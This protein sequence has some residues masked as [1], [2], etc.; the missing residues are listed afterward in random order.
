MVDVTSGGP[1]PD[2]LD[3]E[4]VD[5]MELLR[6]EQEKMGMAMP[7]VVDAPVMAPVTFAAE[8]AADMPALAPLELTS[9][10][11]DIDDVAGAAAGIAAAA[12][13]TAAAMTGTTSQTAGGVSNEPSMGGIDDDALVTSL[14]GRYFINVGEPLPEYA[15]ANAMAFEAM[16]RNDRSRPLM[17]L[18]LEP[19]AQPRYDALEGLRGFAMN[20]MLKL[21]DW[22]V[23]DWPAGGSRFAIVLERP[24]GYRVINDLTI[25]QSGMGDEE[26]VEGL[27]RPLLNTLKD[28]AARGVTHRAIRPTN[29]FYTDMTRRTMVLGECLTGVPALDQPALFETIESAQAH[30]AGRG[31]GT[32]QN[33][34]YS[35]GATIVYLLLGRNPVPD[36]SDD[37]L[38]RE[39]IEVG[40]YMALAGQVRVPVSLIEPLRG[41]LM[42]DERD[43]WTVADLDLWLSGRRQSPRQSK[44]P[45]RASR[46]FLVGE[47]ECFNVRTLGHAFAVNWQE[48]V[49][50]VRS[51]QLDSWLRRSMMEEPKAEAL[52]NAVYSTASHVTG[53]GAEERLVA[54]GCITLDPKGPIRY[55]GIGVT[56]DGIGPAMTVAL[57]DADLRQALTEIIS[58]RLPIHWVA[59]QG[60]PNS[61]DVRIAQAMEKLPGIIEQQAVGLGFERCLYETNPMMRCL[62]PMFEREFVVDISEVMPALDRLGQT[63]DRPDMPYDRHLIGF[64]AARSRRWSEDLLRPLASPDTII[65]AIG[66]LRLF[67]YIQENNEVGPVPGFATWM[68]QMLAPVL[69]NY[70]HRA[71]RQRVQAKVQA[72]AESGILSELLAVIDDLAERQ[73][74]NY[75]FHQAREEYRQIEAELTDME[76][77]VDQREDDARMMGEQIAAVIGAVLTCIV[78]AI[79]FLVL[80]A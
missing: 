64:I 8:G 70:H 27:L 58:A 56:V 41:M 9:V 53:R 71:R 14:R 18:I 32:I 28:L 12:A 68:S 55:R 39:K 31:P 63:P 45:A 78:T 77:N 52:I 34:L 57:N 60:K 46:P 75:G 5:P 79:T 61:E 49:P 13:A 23:V 50:L 69:D 25:P 66:L 72:A 17:A 40:S 4:W 73:A 80:Y 44:L 33:D 24:G 36:K 62:S 15:S 16:F 51:R 3:T 67:S 48:A 76:T 29:L 26:I 37:A 2:D 1:P 54:R 6:Q 38:I 19:E 65:R 10:E 35:L 74:D 47:E 11:Q 43:R 21:L 42:D 30:P 20:G 59:A 22:G 7:E